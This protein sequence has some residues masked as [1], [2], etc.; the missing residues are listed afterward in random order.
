MNLNQLIDDLSLAGVKLWAD[1][2][3]LRVRAP[4]GVLTQ[5]RRDLLS[6]HKAELVSL[7]RYSDEISTRD[8][9]LPLV[10]VS[11]EQD[12]P[13]SFPQQQM[14]FFNQ[15]EP[16]NPFYN[17]AFSVRLN[18]S[19]NIV[20][21]WQSINE[22]IRRHEVLRTTFRE[23]N[24]QL[25]QAIAS[26]LN[27]TIPVVDL[28]Q[29]PNG[30]RE[31]Q[32]QRLAVEEAQHPFNLAIGPMLRGLLLHTEEAEHILLLTVHHIA[33]DGWSGS[34]L[35]QEL[36]ALYEA[37][38]TNQPSPLPELVVQYADFASWQRQWLQGEVQKT[39]FTYW[40]QQ[41]QGAPAVLEIPLDYPRPPSQSFRG[42]KQLLELP[43][44]LSSALKGL[45][46]KEGVSL[47]MT[48]LAAF[49]TLLYRYTNQ[50]DLVVGSPI[51]NRNRSEIE[52]LIGYF[53]NSLV[54]RS[55]LSGN[56]TF[57]ELLARVQKVALE[58][59]A[60]QNL[61]FERLVKELQPERSLSHN[62]L[63]QAVFALQNVPETLALN[64]LTLTV[65]PEFNE[66]ATRCDLELHLW[67]Y[68]EG[69][70][71]F[72]LYSTD[73]FNRTTI[74][75]MTEHF[76]TLLAGIVANPEQTLLELPLLSATEQQKLLLEW[77]DTD[78]EYPKHLCIHELFE[79]K[80]DLTPDAVALVFEDQ[81]LTYNELNVR[82][83]QLAHYLQSIGT[84]PEVLVGLCV[85]R[86]VEMIVGLLGI[87]KAG[88]TYVPL[89]PSYPA[90][91]LAYI[92][93]DARVSVLL[94][95]QHLVERLS[96]HS[97]DVICLDTDAQA[98]A[99]QSQKNPET[100]VTSQ[101]LAY[102][103]YT[104]GSTG[105]PK[106]TLVVHSGLCNLAVANKKTFALGASSHILQ[107]AALSFDASIWE[108]VMA[109]S[110]GATLYLGT[111]TSLLPGKELIDLLRQYQ[112]T[113][114]FL[115]PSALAVLPTSELRA[116]QTILVGGEACSEALVVQWAKGRKFFNAY[117]P[118]EATVCATV[119]ECSITSGKPSIG[120]PIANTQ[121][122]LLDEQL[123]PVPIGVPGEL[124]IS[125]VGLARGYL[126]RPELT[127][128]KFIPN[129][130]SY[131]P[132]AR[133]YKTGDKARYLQDG[134]IEFLGRIDNQVKLR[135]Y[136]IELG[137]IESVLNQHP[138]V[139]Q[140]VA[141]VRE[142]SPGIERIVAYC[143]Q[144]LSGALNT[145]VEPT[146]LP[147][148]YVSQWQTL[149]DQTYAESSQHSDTTF[150]IVGWNSSY[151]NQ[152]IPAEQ[153]RQWLNGRV[154]HLLAF[155]PQRV[156]EIGCGTGLLLFQ[157]APHCQ[158][159]YG[160]DFS[161]VALASIAQQLRHP[162][163]NLPQVQLQQKLAD[164]FADVPD[165]SFDTVILNSVVQ[166]FP[167]IDYLLQVLEGAVKAVA[168]GGIIFVGDVR[169]L[170]LRE[171]FH[172]S[173][174][175]Y[176]A[177]EEL[178]IEQLQ[179]RVQAQMAEET[180]LVIDPEFFLALKEHLPQI[181]SVQIRL[182]RGE[183]HNELTSFRYDVTLEVGSGQSTPDSQL[184]SWHN[185]ETEGLTLES[186]AQLLESQPQ[187]LGIVHIPNA[188]VLSTIKTA[189]LLSGAECPP[190]ISQLRTAINSLTPE[191]GV[192]PEQLWNIAQQHGY[193]L[194][195]GWSETELGCYDVVFVQQSTQGAEKPVGGILP[196][197]R[198]SVQPKAWQ[199]YANNPLQ[200]QK[201][202]QLQSQ[203]RDYLSAR[204][205]E[206]M[207]PS[208]FVM[209]EVLP[210]TPNGKVD[211][212]ALPS[213]EASRTHLS[214]AYVAPRS[215]V[216]EILVSLSAE[217][218]G[219]EQVGIHDN[220]FDLG[221]H[222]LL[223]TQL[224]SRIRDVLQLELPLRSLFEAPTP[225]ELAEWI[226]TIR[227]GQQQPQS[228]NSNDTEH[229]E[230]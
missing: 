219:L 57:R 206:Y 189:E 222:S 40:K 171:A 182:Q 145:T 38:C 6:K 21:L 85:E 26:T 143:T 77:N 58:A 146:Q 87:L 153:M 111:T 113:Q 138:Q 70:R 127:A 155:Q 218:L 95:Q 162:E 124:Y 188:R 161:D 5:Q 131:Q 74:T 141:I 126:N 69:I 108:V 212:K 217:I 210:L 123:Q 80:V 79:A 84:E 110:T 150:N 39:Q 176:Q 15:L 137:E 14:W 154:N 32:A 86:S 192:E 135:G 207:V 149:Y 130:F 3:E 4:K 72:F 24:G 119:A 75:R 159:Y 136:R 173:V 160:T 103:I 139:R 114:V 8:T 2:E 44:S 195:I 61:P 168:P 37:F 20:A 227:W 142:D 157:I 42:A 180:E 54:L 46:Q 216:E 100:G 33:F 31:I 50:Q 158:Q 9:D 177:S 170:P 148:E 10:R 187:Q 56:P 112:I 104:S 165:A 19:L 7:L 213:P 203:L 191:F 221:G 88:G 90:E 224:I 202:R 47:F 52:G 133:L 128:Q 196:L 73:L 22:I 60:H 184:L 116:L 134:N 193:T 67:E 190:S 199:S 35:F 229:I 186:T 109:I 71:G 200:T 89:D 125:G 205:P 65:V 121:V 13:V 91:R 81:Q 106:G 179:Q 105:L 101:N 225:V 118:T 41:L 120:R 34:V 28:R 122:Y 23:V 214:E 181:T 164:D 107:F 64:K 132:G 63:F 115:P 83:N 1:G 18:G 49:Q 183:Y 55:D 93:S 30:E 208:A 129:P 174:Q 147:T 97:A 48:L 197:E 163:W 78:T 117:G 45:S 43:K 98:I 12:L 27:I 102:V 166:Y 76:Q 156:L 223:A 17:V 94:T 25:V 172:A 211:R 62:P 92:V 226:E 144:D 82:A 185:W 220:F 59:Y 201:S 209:L 16:N 175:L 228:F 215:S 36:A 178:S 99:Q 151:T 198:K 152:P 51:A 66:E 169:S 29:L 194:A 230:L 140:A 96:Q 204:L 167:S 68:S 11:R 53:V